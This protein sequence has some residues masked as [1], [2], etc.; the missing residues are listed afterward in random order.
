MNQ[1][2]N[3]F[4]D[5]KSGNTQNFWLDKKPK[6]SDSNINTGIN[7]VTIIRDE[8]VK[9]SKKQGLFEK[10]YNKTKNMTKLG[11]GSNLVNQKITDYENNKITKEE[12]DKVI[13]KYNASQENASQMLGDITASFVGLLSFVSAKKG[14]LL[15]KAKEELGGTSF[16]ADLCYLLKK[17]SIGKYINEIIN[18]KT[19]S[20]I[21]LA[22]GAGLLAGLAKIFVL[23]FNNI[24]S[25]KYKLDKEN[26]KTLTK[27][28]KKQE[29]KKLRKSKRKDNFRNFATGALSG[30][31]SPITLVAGGVGTAVAYVATT[32]ASRFFTS[33]SIDKKD[34]NIKGFAESLKNNAGM[35]ILGSSI[36]ALTAFS[37][38][39]NMNVLKK[40]LDFAV[41]NLKDKQ[42]A[43]VLQE[44]TPYVQLRNT[45]LEN[46]NI[47][48][49]IAKAEKS[50]NSIDSVIQELTDENIF[51]VK[52]LQKEH[53]AI[54]S[55]L[56]ESCPPTRTLEEAQAEI[57]KLLEGSNYEVSKLLGVGTVAE[58]YLAKDATGKEVCIKII[59]KG[60]TK[61]KILNDKQKFVDM[62]TKGKPLETLSQEE[63][64]LLRNIDDLADAILKEVDLSNEMDMAQKLTSCTRKANVVKPI[65]CKNNVYVMEKAN[66]ISLETMTEY[67]R[68]KTNLNSYEN[69][70]KKSTENGYCN[71]NAYYEEKIATVKEK[72]Q[73]LKAKSPDFVD[74]DIST[75]D[76][77]ALSK[78][79]IDVINEQFVKLERGEKYIHGD[80]HPGNIFID[81][82]A[83]KNKSKDKLFT[84]ID[85]GNTINL[86]KEQTIRT[87]KLLSFIKKGNVKDL[88]KTI[89]EDSL[90]PAG[91]T[92][93]KAQELFQNELKKAF[94]DNET[95]IKKM[96]TDNFLDMSK[97]ILKKHN[98]IMSDTQLNYN[99]AKDFA[100][101]SFN[102][103][104]DSFMRSIEENMLEES[105]S[106]EKISAITDFFNITGS[107]VSKSAIEE[108][109]NLLRM[110]PKELKNYFFNK[111]NL[112]GNDLDYLTYVLKQSKK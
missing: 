77:K 27:S 36:I 3:C 52:F 99:K 106:A 59:K 45:M 33:K 71:N 75:D 7:N 96:T 110:S 79:Y 31:L 22:I 13:T 25:K 44:E 73:K 9:N 64:F 53:N 32:T 4:N 54:G 21:A 60:V 87:R 29:K 12:L 46:Q 112:K 47:R 107:Y 103:I 48:E 108:I 58:S 39:R 76:V 17:N 92:R 30:L 11:F 109:K 19:K 104:I 72:I 100:N 34:K 38:G 88:S 89:I 101:K 102:D 1:I 41:K 15:A 91:M 93:E 40:N 66:G 56:K 82:N 55:A 94:F 111:N 51:A 84:L 80:L 2:T 49:L 18:S 14:L 85:M 81:L 61:E 78:D 65:V 43:E 26:E 6:T 68:L 62:I 98:I 67:F 23:K 24:G 16:L 97:N 28:E 86:S 63:N 95:A 42:L 57:N 35:N 74:F 8:F 105:G 70:L 37:K 10:L 69:C 83:L 5:L 50:P 90:L 20:T